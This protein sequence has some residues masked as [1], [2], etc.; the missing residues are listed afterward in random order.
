MVGGRAPAAGKGFGE[1]LRYYRLMSGL[2]QEELADRSG[3]S[4]RTIANMECG[5]T[6]RPYRRSVKSL[7]DALALAGPQREQ[8]DRAFR[9]IT[10][11][12]LTAEMGIPGELAGEAPPLPVPRQ[13]PAAV[14]PFAGRT[15]EL[16]ALTASMDQTSGTK[17][18]LV[19]SAIVGTA[20]VGKTALAVHWAHQVADRFPDGQL[21]VNLRG[22]DPGE[23]MTAADAL[24]GFLRA[25]GV[26]GHDI[27][28]GDGRAGRPVPQPAGRA[29]GAGRAG[30]RRIGGAGQ[31]AAARHSRMPGG[32]DQPRRAGRPDRPGR[33]AAARPGPAPVADAVS[34]LRALI[35]DRVDADPAAAIALAQH[36]SRL[37]LA[38]R[39]AAELAAARPADLTRR[40]G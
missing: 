26:P 36:C 22:Y 7:A 15:D 1:L 9:H 33:R 20:G 29:A 37:P 32:G 12:A 14:A 3:L 34:L 27:P 10:G 25:L 16:N 6:T 39:V 35:G 11:G 18:T 23:P 38:L 28:A 24:A 30:Q 5:R 2:T 4:V 17:A 19:I 21:Y 13:M 31:A 40:A 8:L